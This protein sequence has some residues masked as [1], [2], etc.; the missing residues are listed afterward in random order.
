MAKK[1]K[2]NPYEDKMPMRANI[3]ISQF[4]PETKTTMRQVGEIT[5]RIATV[6][7]IYLDKSTTTYERKT[8]R[9]ILKDYRDDL[10]KVVLDNF[11]YVMHYPEVARRIQTSIDFVDAAIEMHLK[12][13]DDNRTNLY[14]DKDEKSFIK[15]PYGT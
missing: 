9:S 8:L 6:V 14:L 12:D 5:A 1:A 15:G 13:P 11:Y 7:T 3:D 10:G 2:Y 4:H